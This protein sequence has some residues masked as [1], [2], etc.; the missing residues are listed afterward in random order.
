M[1]VKAS[2]FE[3]LYSYGR[4]I[5][6]FHAFGFVPFYY[7]KD[8]QQMVV[9]PGQRRHAADSLRSGKASAKRARSL[10]STW[11][12]LA[13]YASYVALN[14][15]KSI[16]VLLKPIHVLAKA[17]IL[18]FMLL[19]WIAL[20]CS[21]LSFLQPQNLPSI[22]NQL[23]R[24][25]RRLPGAHGAAPRKYV[26][27]YP[28]FMAFHAY[29]VFTTTSAAFSKPEDPR[30]VTAFLDDAKNCPFYLRCLNATYYAFTYGMF[31]ATLYVILGT[32]AA[33][34]DMAAQVC[35]KM[36]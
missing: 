10:C 18:F 32:A 20:Y 14:S 30:F 31:I 17:Y 3:T 9:P 1:G 33:V 27:I 15:S 11:L 35:S 8:A 29:N 16:S 34:C 23:M 36:A 25:S 2:P 12:K 24:T 26:G 13:L 5:S 6:W 28:V 21:N 4:M 22:I 7:S 19:L